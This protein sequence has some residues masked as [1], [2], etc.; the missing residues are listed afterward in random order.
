MT[1]DHRVSDVDL[2]RSRPIRNRE[3]DIGLIEGLNEELLD[4]VVHGV[5]GGLAEGLRGE[6]T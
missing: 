2:D 4:L 3:T 5:E 6:V 1:T